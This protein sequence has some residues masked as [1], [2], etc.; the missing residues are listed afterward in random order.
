MSVLF[1]DEAH[2][3]RLGLAAVAL[4]MGAHLAAGTLNQAALARDRAGAAAACWLGSAAVFVAWMLLDVVEDAL[5]RAEVGY[6]GAASLLC[7]LLSGV[8]RR[9]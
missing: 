8:Y 9:E 3:G 1:E 5:T 6:L 2:Y 4:G 7:L